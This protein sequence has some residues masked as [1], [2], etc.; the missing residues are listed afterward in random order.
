MA[1]ASTSGRAARCV[2]F[3]GGGTAGHVFP[4]L[5]VAEELARRWDGRI[6]WIGSRSGPEG[7]LAAE[8][9]MPFLPV[10][11][12]KL[13]RYVS[14]RNITDVFRI[15]AGLAASLRAL[16]RERPALLFSKGGF[17]SVPPVVAARLLGIPAYTHESDVDPGLATRINAK[18]CERVFVSHPE[19]VSFFPEAERRRVAVT[20]NPVRSFFH[21]ADPVEGRRLAGC[22]PGQ[23]LV[24]AIGGSLGAASLNALVAA[25]APR[26]VA[27]GVRLLHQVGERAAGSRAAGSEAAG[28]EAAGSRGPGAPTPPPAGYTTFAF[29]GVELPH[30]LAAADLVVCRAGGN[31]LAELATLGKPA[32]LVP[33]PTGGSRGDQLRNAELFRRRGA[34]EVLR[35][36]GATSSSLLAMIRGLLSDPERRQAM[37]RAA[38]SLAGDEAA[39]RIADMIVE[40]IGQGA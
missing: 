7:R 19:T 32:I 16:S 28:P 10:P 13:R 33:L 30:L 18:F 39:S 9:G 22:A 12:G 11:A 38:R 8:A 15:M 4:G 6:I 2:A 14:L 40:R 31:T 23:P 29:L 21:R 5:A 1:T 36:E 3:T 37:S 26:L 20:G 17:V 34:A 25:S 27:E 35:E 24:L